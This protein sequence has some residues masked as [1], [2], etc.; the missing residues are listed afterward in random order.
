[1][2]GTKAKNFRASSLG[3]LS[4][5]IGNPDPKSLSRPDTPVPRES[6]GTGRYYVKWA[7]HHSKPK[8]LIQYIYVVMYVYYVFII[9]VISY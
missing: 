1:M 4:L 2:S 6:L 8:Q 3:F 7:R 9:Y 5:G